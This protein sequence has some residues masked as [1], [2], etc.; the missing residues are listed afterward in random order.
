VSTKEINNT[1]KVENKKNLIIII[2]IIGIS[3]EEIIYWALANN[4][5]ELLS[6]PNMCALCKRRMH[7]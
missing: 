3:W 1:Y 4:V 2:I 7:T 5:R 6:D